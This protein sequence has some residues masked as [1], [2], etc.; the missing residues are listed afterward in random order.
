[1]AKKKVF[2]SYDHSEDVL[3]KRMLEAWDANTNFDFEFDH[4]SPSVA[5]DSVDAAVIKAALTKKMKESE[6]LLV[7]VGE[8][9]HKSKWVSW[10]IERAKQSDTKLKLAAVK[11]DKNNITPSGL[12]NVGTAWAFSFT[13][14]NIVTALDEAT[15]DY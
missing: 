9:V 12:L 8:K 11:L 3:Y 14:D 10:E 6:Y 15:N 2:I 1:M 4:R 7:I 13:K 5:I